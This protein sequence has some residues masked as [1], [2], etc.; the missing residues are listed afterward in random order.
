VEPEGACRLAVLREH[1]LRPTRPAGA[2]LPQL[3]QPRIELAPG[4]AVELET[5]HGVAEAVRRQREDRP[6]VARRS[7]FRAR[8]ADRIT[9]AEK[10]LV[11]LTAE[12]GGLAPRYPTYLW[13]RL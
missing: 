13:D 6:P 11:V 10:H 12:W 8:L 1:E 7:R 4:A 3:A 2:Q 9:L 5:E